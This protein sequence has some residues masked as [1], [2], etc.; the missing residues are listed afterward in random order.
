MFL[1]NFWILI[2]LFQNTTQY[3]FNKYPYFELM[4][5]KNNAVIA[6]L[7]NSAQID[8]RWIY[9]RYSFRCRKYPDFAC[10]KRRKF[11]I[12]FVTLIILTILTLFLEPNVNFWLDQF[13][14]IAALF[15]DNFTVFD[16]FDRFSH[17]AGVIILDVKIVFYKMIE[18]ILSRTIAHLID[19]SDK[20]WSRQTYTTQVWIRQIK[21]RKKLENYL[22]Y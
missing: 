2:K 9:K 22:L 6:H 12:Y 8:I 20:T 16:F 18:C 5:H 7:F 4:I 10:L 17:L 15:L 14:Q 1:L 19:A 11:L 21:G 3:L 13:L